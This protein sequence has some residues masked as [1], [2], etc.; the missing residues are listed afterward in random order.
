MEALKLGTLEPSD[1][2]VL[3]H[4]KAGHRRQVKPAVPTAKSTQPPDII[5]LGSDPQDRLGL[6]GH[7]HC[8]DRVL[9]RRP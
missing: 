6:S 3:R 7:R 1:S 9:L 2:T 4:S 5:P 8:S